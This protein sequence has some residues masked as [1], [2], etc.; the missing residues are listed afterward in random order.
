ME[1][2]STEAWTA[3]KEAEF[4]RSKKWGRWPSSA[5]AIAAVLFCLCGLFQ[6]ASLLVDHPT[7]Q[8]M[9]TGLVCFLYGLMAAYYLTTWQSQRESV[10]RKRDGMYLVVEILRRHEKSADALRELEQSRL[11]EDGLPYWTG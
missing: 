10:R 1:Q 11:G 7:G 6:V 8:R 5:L 9:L 3:Q 4:A 2:R